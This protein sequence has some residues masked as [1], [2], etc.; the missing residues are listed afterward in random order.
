MH[1]GTQVRYR[2]DANPTKRLGNSAG[3]KKGRLAPLH[4]ADAEEWW[5]RRAAESGLELLSTTASAMPDIL[6]SR[7]RDRRGRCRATSHGVTRFEGVAVVA[8]PEK[9]RS[10]VV[11][12]VGR[13][14]TYGCGLLSIEPV[15]TSGG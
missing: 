8:D 1:S 12:G 15:P 11:E 4:G 14:R 6:G 7:N 13:A 5:H 10:A 9:V 3:D 2:I